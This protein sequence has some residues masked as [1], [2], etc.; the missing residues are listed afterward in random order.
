MIDILDNR[1]IFAP[2]THIGATLRTYVTPECSRIFYDES[3]SASALQNIRHISHKPAVV[4]KEAE[5][6]VRLKAKPYKPEYADKLRK[7]TS[8]AADLSLRATQMSAD[9]C[10]KAPSA[11]N[12]FADYTILTL[13]SSMQRTE[14]RSHF[15][16]LSRSVC[17]CKPLHSFFHGQ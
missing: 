13:R 7:C 12:P 2:Y 16:F 3:T 9:T 10:Q 11:P 14:I 6:Q 1:I 15:Q 17:A 4:A 5:S 8:P